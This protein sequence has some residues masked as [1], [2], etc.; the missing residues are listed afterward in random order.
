MSNGCPE[1]PPVKSAKTPKES[2]GIENAHKFKRYIVMGLNA[3]TIPLNIGLLNRSVAAEENQFE[4]SAYTHNCWIKDI[5]NWADK[6]LGGTRGIKQVVLVGDI[7]AAKESIEKGAAA[8]KRQ[9]VLGH[10]LKIYIGSENY[11]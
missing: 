10:M 7:S 3:K 8:D 9:V 4:R 6:M 2:T 1:E 11:A 5:A